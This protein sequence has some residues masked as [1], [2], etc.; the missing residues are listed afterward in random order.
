MEEIKDLKTQIINYARTREVYE[1]YRKAGYSKKFY[2]EHEADI[3]L[4]KAAKKHFDELGIKK[5]HTVKSLSA[6]YAEL[7]A[8]KKKAYGEYREAR[9]EMKELLLV[10]ANIDTIMGKDGKAHDDPQKKKPNR[11]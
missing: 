4:H 1:A 2:R 3:L 5:P 7:L 9:D 6:E 11:Q 8:E 10:K